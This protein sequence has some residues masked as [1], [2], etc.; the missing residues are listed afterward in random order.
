MNSASARFIKIAEVSDIPKGEGK[1]CLIHG[2]EIA[3]FH[4]ES[5][6][7]RAV[8]NVCPHQKGPLAHGIL[9]GEIVTCPLHGWKIDLKT[10]EA[11]GENGRVATYLICIENG[12][13]WIG[14]EY[15]PSPLY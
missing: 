7:V 12:D 6:E 5:G 1:I 9:T 2:K 3:L 10:G 14:L 4:L 8:D 13:I 15:I 11:I